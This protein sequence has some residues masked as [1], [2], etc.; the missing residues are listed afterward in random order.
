MQ[1][2]KDSRE[3][4][5]SPYMHIKVLR[6]QLA[7]NKKAERHDFK[8]RCMFHLV[9]THAIEV[10]HISEF[11]N[12]VYR[13]ALIVSRRCARILQLIHLFLRTKRPLTLNI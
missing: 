2:Y 8:H 13:Y 11:E 3:L 7:F 12:R 1:Q 5:S 10:E 4:T 9:E 6:L